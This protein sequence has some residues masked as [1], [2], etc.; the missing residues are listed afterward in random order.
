[1]AWN[2]GRFTGLAR[3]AARIVALIAL[4]WSGAADAASRLVVELADPVKVIV[5][6][7]PVVGAA[8]R[9]VVNH[10]Q[11]GHHLLQFRAP[12]GKLAHEVNVEVGADGEVRGRYS[13][14]MGLVFEGALASAQAAPDGPTSS[15]AAEAPPPPDD[16]PVVSSFDMN[17][18]SNSG[19]VAGL[20]PSE[21][22]NRAQYN[23]QRVAG[24][25]ARGAVAMAVPAAPTAL[26]VGAVAARGASSMVRNAPAGGVSAVNGSSS[27]ARQGRPIPPKAVTGTVVVVSTAGE[28]YVVYI[29]GF[30]V[31]ELDVTRPSRKVR[32]EIG[33]HTLEMWDADTGTVRW[34]GVAEV[35]K[36]SVV[37]VE[38][39][40]A[41]AP[42]AAS[43]SW[44]WS[45]R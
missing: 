30:V 43:R 23:A 41:V 5:D 3:N 6:G 4:V 24:G 29:E 35:T 37:K 1:M 17:D 28:P 34:K 21:G 42:H 14:A 2:T 45:N 15:P 44:A 13:L 16:K 12:D 10:I 38:F 25:V 36:D 8:G 39:S 33:R 20:G 9:A 18:G 22:P 31:A 32:L 7:R 11:P 26:A 27:R 40:D 19:K